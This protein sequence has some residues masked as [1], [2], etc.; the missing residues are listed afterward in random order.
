MDTALF[1]TRSTSPNPIPCH[2]RTPP[3]QIAN[4]ADLWQTESIKKRNRQK[5]KGTIRG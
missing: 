2:F 4:G 1:H 5:K 3:H